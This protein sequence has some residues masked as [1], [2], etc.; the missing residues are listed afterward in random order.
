MMWNYGYESGY[1]HPMMWSH[2]FGLMDGFLTFIWII[3]L[4]LVIAALVRYLR[5]GSFHLGRNHSLD[6]LKERYAKGEIDKTEFEE[7]RETLSKS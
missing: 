2:G 1:G 3:L 6:I 4:A 7:K 5:S